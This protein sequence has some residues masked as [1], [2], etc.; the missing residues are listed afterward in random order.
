MQ[1]LDRFF[2][3]SRRIREQLRG[4]RNVNRF[5]QEVAAVFFVDRDLGHGKVGLRK[6]HARRVH[7]DENL[8]DRLD[9]QVFGQID[10]PNVIADNFPQLLDRGKDLVLQ[11]VR[12]L[13]AIVGYQLKKTRSWR[14]HVRYI[15]DPS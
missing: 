10:H 13:L 2:R 3:S 4:G 8:G 1:S 6:F 9:V 5:A 12:I 7:S 14:E 15:S 11:C